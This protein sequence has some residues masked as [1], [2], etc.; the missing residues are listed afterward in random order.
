MAESMI[1]KS[2]QRQR[3]GEHR[4]V[5]CFLLSEKLSH[6]AG[7]SH[8]VSHRSDLSSITFKHTALPAS[9]STKICQVIN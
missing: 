6:F 2:F 5:I 7:R 4:S 8:L 1:V 9:I 3:A